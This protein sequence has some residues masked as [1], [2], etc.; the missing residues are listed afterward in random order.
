MSLD[1][2]NKKEKI[3]VHYIAWILLVLYI[4]I[5]VATIF[6]ST[7][8]RER[9]FKNY[10]NAK[11]YTLV[12]G[13]DK[14][15]KQRAQYYGAMVIGDE[16]EKMIKMTSLKEAQKLIDKGEIVITCQGSLSTNEL[17][18]TLGVFLQELKQH[19]LYKNKTIKRIYVL[20]QSTKDE[21]KEEYEKFYEKNGVDPYL[22]KDELGAT[23][24]KILAFLKDKNKKI[25][26][27][28]EFTSLDIDF[29]RSNYNYQSLIYST[30]KFLND[31]ENCLVKK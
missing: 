1:I 14:E 2:K 6:L 19:P 30:L 9:K 22:Y 15:S 18:L 13:K 11:V 24:P 17:A 29:K 12:S 5:V 10:Y 4:S 21:K 8:T 20:E 26:E 28:H 7:T 27:K 16:K 31:V 23:N 3:K 25:A